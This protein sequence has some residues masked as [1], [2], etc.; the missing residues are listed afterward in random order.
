M[1]HLWQLHVIIEK[2][3]ITSAYCLL[4]LQP[5]SVPAVVK[6]FWQLHIQQGAVNCQAS[7][8][9]CYTSDISQHRIIVVHSTSA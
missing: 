7:P 9:K 8:A 5:A 3:K 6:L 4:L 2:N 1:L